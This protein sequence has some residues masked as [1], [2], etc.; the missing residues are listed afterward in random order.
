MINA[1]APSPEDEY[2]IYQSLIAGFP[3]DEQVTPEYVERLKAYYIKS[4]RE[5]KL[6]T[7]WQAPDTQYEEAG[8]RFIEKIVSSEH[9]FVKSFLPFFKKIVAHAQLLSLTQTLVKITAPGVPDIYQGSEGWDTSYVDPDNRRPVDFEIYKQYVKEIKEREQKGPA[10]VLKYITSKRAEGLEKFY[11]TWKALQ[12]RR[13]LAAV[14]L[15]GDYI[16]LYASDNC[17]VIAYA[18]HYKN[19]WVLVIAP[20]SM[21]EHGTNCSITLPANAP[22]KWRNIF[23]GETVDAAGDLQIHTLFNNFPVTL[24][25]GEVK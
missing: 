19:E 5:A 3:A 13:Q 17:G 7:N 8:C 14:F 24:L 11:V 22:V 9:D 10:E 4:I 1:P 15:H 18:R 21:E 12:C 16:P 20:V 6:F 2:F 25:T 23:T